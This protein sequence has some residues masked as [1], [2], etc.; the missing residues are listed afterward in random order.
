MDKLKYHLALSKIFDL[1]MLKYI[2]TLF[3]FLTEKSKMDSWKLNV[4]CVVGI[5]C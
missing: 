2:L 3:F 1:D 4:L 5:K